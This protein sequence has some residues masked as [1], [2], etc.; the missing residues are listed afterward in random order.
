MRA[1]EIYFELKE[2]G[3]IKYFLSINIKRDRAN[4]YIFFSQESFANKILQEFVVW[5][6]NPVHTPIDVKWQPPP[7]QNEKKKPAISIIT[8]YQRATGSA[9]WLST[10]TRPDLT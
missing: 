2:L 5:P 3:N 8:H 1:M 4:Y 9:N 6:I 10:N 7:L